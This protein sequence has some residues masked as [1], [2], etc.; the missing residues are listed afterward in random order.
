[1]DVVRSGRAEEYA[2]SRDVRGIAPASGRNAL[3]YLAAAHR[4][5]A[6]RGGVVRRY[7]AGRDAVH[8]HALRET[9]RNQQET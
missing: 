2:G 1:M 9:N 6:K 8:V 5:C 3:E 7:V 4:V